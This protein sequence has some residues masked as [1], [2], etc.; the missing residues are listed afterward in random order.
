[1]IKI[2]SEWDFGYGD[3][4]FQTE[5]AALATLKADSN[6]KEICIEYQNTVEGLMEDGLISFKSVLLG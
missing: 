1:M 6:V 2:D 5:A 4:V 3:T